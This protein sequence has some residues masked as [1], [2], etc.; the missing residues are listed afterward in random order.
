MKRRQIIDDLV[1]GATGFF[2]DDRD[3]LGRQAAESR[4]ITSAHL[5]YD[6]KLIGHTYSHRDEI[7]YATATRWGAVVYR[8]HL[9]SLSDDQLIREAIL[10]LEAA[11]RA[12]SDL[13]I[14]EREAIARRNREFARRGGAV[15][16]R[17][18]VIAEACRALNIERPDITTKA[19]WRHLLE[20]GYESSDGRVTGTTVSG[21]DRLAQTI[22]SET[23][24]ISFNTFRREYWARRAE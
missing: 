20:R 24:S 8:N 17:A 6:R 5:I 22:G 18:T 7:T 9:E 11:E 23:K 3:L 14:Q 4:I 1:R 10:A 21:E 12:A 2:G 15:S 19:A 13:E 16:K